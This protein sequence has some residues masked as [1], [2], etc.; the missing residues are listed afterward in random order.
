MNR[1]REAAVEAEVEAATDML[2]F[3]KRCLL[4][5]VLGLVAVVLVAVG[6]RNMT[7]LCRAPVENVETPH[8][9]RDIAVA[10][11]EPRVTK[12]VCAANQS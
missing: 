1:K 9:L 7:S 6:V 3:G 8:T 2:R 5:G 12:E 4:R 10:E 11:L